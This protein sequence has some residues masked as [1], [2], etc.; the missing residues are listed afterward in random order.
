MAS[1]G[2]GQTSK[3]EYVTIC[4]KDSSGP[5]DY[6]LRKKLVG[7]AKEDYIEYAIDIFNFYGSDASA[8]VRAGNNVRHGLIG[9]GVDASHGYE[10]THK[11]GIL[12]TL[13]LLGKYIES[14]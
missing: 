1:P 8:A 13:K 7:L 14:L 5:Y 11:L 12:N 9:P 10:R 6:E 3:E 4:A 2:Q